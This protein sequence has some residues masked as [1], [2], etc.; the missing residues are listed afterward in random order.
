MWCTDSKATLYSIMMAENV[1]EQ[2]RMLQLLQ[3]K[4]WLHNRNLSARE[5]NKILGFFNAA[6]ERGGYDETEIL[7]QLPISLSHEI[8]YHLY[9]RFIHSMPMF[10]NLGK[11]ILNH[12]C[13][14]VK[15]TYYVKD[16][17]I[18]E[19]GMIGRGRDRHST[20]SFAPFHGH[21]PN[22]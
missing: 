11:E 20:V 7:S 19:E 3:V 1:G 12:L 18:Y 15:T 2:E 4:G 22:M 9:A 5:R 17:V 14:L 10:S 8:S 16:S 13:R 21:S 6:H